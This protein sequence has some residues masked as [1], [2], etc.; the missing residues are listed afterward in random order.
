MIKGTTQVPRQATTQQA[1]VPLAHRAHVNRKIHLSGLLQTTD[2]AS[3]TARVSLYINLPFPNSP[4]ASCSHSPSS[5]A[6]AAHLASYTVASRSRNGHP[7]ARHMLPQ[8]APP[9][10]IPFIQT[11]MCVTHEWIAV[12][13]RPWQ[14][15][16]AQQAGEI[17]T[18]MPW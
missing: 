11:A 8:V 10:P 5:E 18:Q 17:M 4:M 13:T 16:T 14:V 12:G 15:R 9:H 3:Y 6:F 7:N 1:L 2:T